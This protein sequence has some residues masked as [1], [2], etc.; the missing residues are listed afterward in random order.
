MK[1]KPARDPSFHPDQKVIKERWIKPKLDEMQTEI[2]QKN[3]RSFQNLKLK[4]NHKAF[5]KN[6]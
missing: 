1:E 2:C 6:L 4:E 5:K 3:L